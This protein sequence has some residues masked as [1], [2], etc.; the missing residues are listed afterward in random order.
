MYLVFYHVCILYSILTS[1][2]SFS[3]IFYPHTSLLS[4]PDLDASSGK[5]TL[6]WLMFLLANYKTKFERGFH[7]TVV[8]AI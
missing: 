4:S 1:V 5:Q 6:Y 8:T 7:D 3:E 2:R